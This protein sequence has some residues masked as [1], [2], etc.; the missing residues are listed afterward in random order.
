MLPPDRTKA[1]RG[2]GAARMSLA[3]QL[4]QVATYH[5]AA[6]DVELPMFRR[7]RKNME[8]MVEQCYRRRIQCCRLDKFFPPSIHR[9]KHTWNL[10]QYVFVL[11][12]LLQ[13]YDLFV[14]YVW[15]RLGCP[16]GTTANS[17]ELT[18]C[19]GWG[20]PTVGSDQVPEL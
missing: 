7:C 13:F 16:C 15:T 5:V 12:I 9:R 18:E 1:T 20:C 19:R 14:P 10:L 17:V 2:A 11:T 6:T 4:P 8:N 3:E